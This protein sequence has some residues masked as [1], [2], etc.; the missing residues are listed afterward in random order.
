MKVVRCLALTSL[1][2]NKTNLIPHKALTLLDSQDRAE[3]VV[4]AMAP[5]GWCFRLRINRALFS[6]G[7]LFELGGVLLVVGSGGWGVA[8]GFIDLHVLDVG[9]VLRVRRWDGAGRVVGGVV[10][11]SVL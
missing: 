4:R 1:R 6:F 7:V 8:I 2:G 9:V 3:G 10:V 5:P 11:V